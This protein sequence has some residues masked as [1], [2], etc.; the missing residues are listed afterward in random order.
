VASDVV[1]VLALDGASVPSTAPP[2]G[3]RG[4]ATAGPVRRREGRAA[5]AELS[6]RRTADTPQCACVTAALHTPR[7]EAWAAA[8]QSDYCRITRGLVKIMK[9]GVVSPRPAC[10]RRLA[11]NVCLNVCP[12]EVL[13]RVLDG[14]FAYRFVFL[15]LLLECVQHRHVG[16]GRPRG[17][18][19]EQTA[20]DAC[21]HEP[22]EDQP[23]QQ[24]VVVFER[25]HQSV[26]DLLDPHSVVL[27]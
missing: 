2:N 16:R 4:R 25:D 22:L 27:V 3:S 26:R 19:S 20:C 7:G 6:A 21:S 10:E 5:S 1:P 17:G 8:A 18:D 13:A 11:L 9:H 23:P 12:P 14:L 15:M 24:Q